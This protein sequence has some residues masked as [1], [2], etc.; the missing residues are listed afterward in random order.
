MLALGTNAT[1]LGLSFISALPADN[2]VRRAATAADEGFAA[3]A[4]SPTE[5]DLEQPGIAARRA[6]LGK[7]ERLI[8]GEPGVAAVTGPREQPA[9]PAPQ[10]LVTSDGSAARLAVILDTDPSGATAIEHLERLRD[11]LPGLLRASGLGDAGVRVSGETAVAGE[12]VDAVLADLKRIGLVALAVNLVLLMVFLRALIAP[13]YLVAVSVLGL[14]ASLGITTFVFQGLLGYDDLTY[15]VPFAAAVLLVALGSDYNVFVAGRIWEEA[16]WMRLREAI[17]VA[18]PAAAKAIT[19]AGI[20]LAASFALLA[21]VPLRSFREFAFVMAVGALIDTFLV[22]S[23]LPRAHVAVRRAE[24]VARAAAA[25]PLERGDRRPR[26][27]PCRVAAGRGRGADRRHA[28]S[29]R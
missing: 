7:L 11:R 12:T 10:L 21:L 4:L 27:R 9:P 24:L 16:R 5:I 25:P 23:L 22:R 19:V 29:A 15:Y 3:G 26:G 8:R 17:A 6:E 2:E 20:A 1:Q 18:T 14:A 28:G 13:L